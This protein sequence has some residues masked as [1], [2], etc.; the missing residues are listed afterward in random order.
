MSKNF[1]A[2]VFCSF[3]C[4]FWVFPS[5]ARTPSSCIPKV[6]GLGEVK[7]AHGVVT[8]SYKKF[9][10]Q[11]VEVETN[12]GTSDL[13]L[14]QN[15]SVCEVVFTNP[16]NEIVSYSSGVEPPIAQQFAL[17]LVKA[18]IKEKGGINQYQNWLNSIIEKYP[19]T[20]FTPEEVWALKQLNIKTSSKL[21]T[22][23]YSSIIPVKQP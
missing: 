22:F 16:G 18:S 6:V 21:K 10:Y 11:L 3:L 2:L 7:R 14:K 1:I 13:I 17:Y 12:K 15:A 20:P 23:P 4:V 5:H 19:K 9:D 8:V